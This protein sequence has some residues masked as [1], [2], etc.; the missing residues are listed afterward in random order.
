MPEEYAIA[1]QNIGWRGDLNW[2]AGGEAGTEAECMMFGG[3]W[4][5]GRPGGSARFA[6][7]AHGT[8]SERQMQNAFEVVGLRKQIHQMNLLNVIPSPQ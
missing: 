4:P 6:A 5:G 7:P 8:R 2:K 1:A 3:Q